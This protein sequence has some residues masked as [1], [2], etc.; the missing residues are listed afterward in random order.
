MYAP[1]PKKMAWPKDTWPAY[2]PRMFQAEAEI[3]AS[4]TRAMVRS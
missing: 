3:A 1:A 2:P 4:S